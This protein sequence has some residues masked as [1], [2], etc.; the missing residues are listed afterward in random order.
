MRY[1][2]NDNVTFSLE[3]INLTD[4][5]V[6]MYNTVGTGTRQWFNSELNA[7]PRLMAGVQM[8]F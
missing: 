5:N 7:G 2:W 8:Q 1:R 4:E 3:G 6:R